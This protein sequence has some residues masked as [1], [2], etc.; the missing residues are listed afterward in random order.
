MTKLT[1]DI[2]LALRRATFTVEEAATLLG[3]SRSAAYAAVHSGEIP[4]RP[5]GR[6][7]VIPKIP[8]LESLGIDPADWDDLP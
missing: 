6:R 7:I 4:S 8:F 5:I 2:S 3:I 1:T